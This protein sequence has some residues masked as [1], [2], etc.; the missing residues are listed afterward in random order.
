M[1]F[2]KSLNHGT[3]SRIEEWI[4]IDA[5]ENT[6]V[7]EWEG[8]HPTGNHSSTTVT[9]MTPTR[10]TVAEQTELDDHYSDG[11]DDLEVEVVNSSLN[12]ADAEFDKGDYI[13]AELWY[14]KAVGLAQRLSTHQ[15][16]ALGLA[17]LEISTSLKL[18]DAKF[19]KRNYQAAELGYRHTLNLAQHPSSDRRNNLELGDLAEVSLRLAICCFHLQKFTEAETSLQKVLT[20]PIVSR[21]DSILSLDAAYLQVEIHLS[22]QSLKAAE[23][24]CKKVLAGRRKILGKLHKSYLESVGLLSIIMEAEHDAIS[25]RMYSE[26]VENGMLDTLKKP[27]ETTKASVS[28][29]NATKDVAKESLVSG[30]RGISP[31]DVL[32]GM[33]EINERLVN[34]REGPFDMTALLYRAVEEGIEPAVRLL[35]TACSPNSYIPFLPQLQFEDHSPDQLFIPQFQFEYQSGNEP[36]PKPANPWSSGVRR[37]PEHGVLLYVAAIKGHIGITEILLDAGFDV[38]TQDNS[39]ATPLHYLFHT[40][41]ESQ[42]RIQNVNVEVVKLLLERGANGHIADQSGQV[43]EMYHPINGVE[44]IKTYHSFILEKGLDSSEY[45]KQRE[46]NTWRAIELGSK[47]VL[48]VLLDF[49]V[50][51][52]LKDVD[53]STIS[54]LAYRNAYK[55][56]NYQVGDATGVH[57]LL[58]SRIEIEERAAKQAEWK[59]AREA[60]AAK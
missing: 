17:D 53:G 54:G 1:E 13:A 31:I 57:K 29:V 35:L 41:V 10:S 38:N 36:K 33:R 47:A 4:E 2:G 50:S 9:Q 14:G 18:A 6:S 52:Y 58:L 24:E 40:P 19:E 7:R 30:L 56:K 46:A 45:Q 22:T 49:G 11:G 16:N 12:I 51:P 5:S 25:A 48:E 60:R 28:D 20:L 37:F 8:Q 3:Q 39:G 34:G 55:A 32:L 42:A 26:L 59:A 21:Q 27:Q 44:H 15:Q 23:K 43:P